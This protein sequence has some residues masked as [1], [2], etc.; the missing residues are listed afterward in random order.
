[1]TDLTKT[2]TPRERLSRRAGSFTSQSVQPV[3]LA[4]GPISGLKLGAESAVSG[5]LRGLGA[6]SKLCRFSYSWEINEPRSSIRL[7]QGHVESS[8]SCSRSYRFKRKAAQGNREVDCVDSYE[9]RV[10]Y[11]R[12]CLHD[13]LNRLSR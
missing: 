7:V 11:K 10:I 5:C 2:H 8:Q 9:W 6:R 13:N 12:S 1:M 3:P 4:I